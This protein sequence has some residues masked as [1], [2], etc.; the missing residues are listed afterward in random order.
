MTLGRPGRS[1]KSRSRHDNRMSREPLPKDDATKSRMQKQKST[2]TRPEEALRDELLRRHFR[3]ETNVTGLPGK[4]DLV[5]P[6]R[7]V[8]VFVNGCFWHGCPRHYVEPKHNRRWWREK[9]AGNRGRD[10]RNAARLRRL[11]WS[12]LTVWEH[13]DPVR[14]ADRIQRHMRRSADRT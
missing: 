5:L 3:V 9:I 8:V 7:G 14:A 4:P 10:R 6:V 2:G 12:V 1:V 11:G 13:E